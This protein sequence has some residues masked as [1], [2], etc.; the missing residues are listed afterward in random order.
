[1]PI[2]E[3]LGVLNFFMYLPKI[4]VHFQQLITSPKCNKKY[5]GGGDK[6]GLRNLRQMGFCQIYPQKDYENET[7]VVHKGAVQSILRTNISFIGEG[8]KGQM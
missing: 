2:F 4:I 1:M 7:N 6:G 3:K 8:G 5:R